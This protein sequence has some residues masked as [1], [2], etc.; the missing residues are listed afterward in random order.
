MITQA[1]TGRMGDGGPDD[2]KAQGGFYV[3]QPYETANTL[4]RRMF[5]GVNSRLDEGQTPVVCS[6]LTARPWADHEAQHTKLVV[7]QYGDKAAA[8]TCEGADASPCADRGPTVIAFHG[9]Q[10][11]DVS[12]DISHPVARNQ[13][14]E[15]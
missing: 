8:L 6:T 14:R 9:S 10:D 2:N 5:K 12:G 4:T 15:C 11:P 3:P 7:S 1:L 13:G